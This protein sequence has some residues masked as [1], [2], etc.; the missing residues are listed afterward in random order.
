MANKRAKKKKSTKKSIVT[1]G[2]VN[3]QSSVDQSQLEEMGLHPVTGNQKQRGYQVVTLSRL[4]QYMGRNEYGK[5]ES[6]PTDTPLF[7]LTPEERFRI[8]QTCAPVLG[9]ISS[10]MNRIAGMNWVVTSDKDQEDRIVENMKSLYQLSKEFEGQMDIKYMVARVKILQKLQEKLVDLLPDLSN[11]QKSLIR[12]KKRIEFANDDKTSEIKKWLEHPNPQKKWRDFVKEWVQD[13]LLHGAAALYKESYSNRVDSLYLLSGGSVIPFRTEFVSSSIVYI[14]IPYGKEYQVFRP[15]ELS[16]SQYLPTS[17]RSYGIVP[18]E[19]LINKVTESLLFDRLMAEQADGS[20]FPEKLIVVMDNS[21]FG[22]IDADL[23]VPSGYD[24]QKRLEDKL[25]QKIEGG[26]LTFNG[27]NAEI[28][29]LSRENTMGMQNDRQK[30][31]REDVAMV[32]NMSN[33][34]VNLTGS[35]DTSGR[36][37]SETQQEIEQGKG[38]APVVGAFEDTINHD[39]L[40]YRYGV[41]YEVKLEL[42]K[43]ERE[44]LELLQIKMATGV[45]SVNE[46]RTNDLGEVPFSKEEYDFPPGAGAAIPPDG[47]QTNPFNMKGL[48]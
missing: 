44:E 19:A 14:Q 48:G 39:V 3:M 34:E 27:S 46:I 43:S 40:P 12:W 32:F 22:S 47:S 35:G 5:L 8:M 38:V 21:P 18:L 37:T 9:V 31:I 29:D 11:F 6:V 25:K 45:Y 17:M 16:F 36:S 1:M 26:I 33:M 24:N 4:M 15:H 41:G 42:S 30:D 2:G 23:K 13:Y 7:F 10:R 20:R 28:V